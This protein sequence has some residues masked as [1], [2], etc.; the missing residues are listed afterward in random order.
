[1]KSDGFINIAFD[2]E[3]IDRYVVR[4]S[5]KNALDNCMV[6]FKGRLLD[7]GCGKMPYKDYVL[8]KSNIKE[9]VGLDI[10]NALEYDSSIKPDYT[11]DGIV[12]PF[13]SNSFSTAIGTEVLEHCYEPEVILK[14]VHRVLESIFVMK[15]LMTNIDILHF[16]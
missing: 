15:Y 8:E 12:M 3:S 7:I 14:E 9:Y 6:Q 16:L 1:M 2:Y 10:E 11:W 4:N 5:I 13:D